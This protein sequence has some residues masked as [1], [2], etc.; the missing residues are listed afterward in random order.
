M[1]VVEMT[2]KIP[3][4]R[5]TERGNFASTTQKPVSNLHGKFILTQNKPDLQ[6]FGSSFHNL[7]FLVN[8]NFVFTLLLN[9]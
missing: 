6:T 9:E 7:F 2:S 3:S 4:Y 8:H 1:V 5:F